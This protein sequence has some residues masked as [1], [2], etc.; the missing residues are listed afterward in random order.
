MMT[1]SNIDINLKAYSSY[2]EIT[3]MSTSIFSKINVIFAH[4]RDLGIKKNILAN[5]SGRQYFATQ[6]ILDPPL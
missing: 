3:V 4:I 6:K 2:Y 1:S 5:H